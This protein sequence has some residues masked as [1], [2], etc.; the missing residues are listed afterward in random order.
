[1]LIRTGR[2]HLAFLTS[3]V[4]VVFTISATQGANAASAQVNVLTYHNNVRRNGLN[5]KEAILTPSKV[6]AGIFGKL[7]SLPVDGYIYAQPLYV[8]G[9]NIPGK[10]IHN[11][12]FVATEYDS[13]YAFAAGNPNGGNPL[14]RKTLIDP[15]NITSVSSS[16]LGCTD[17]VP[18]VGITGTPVINLTTKTLYVVSAAFNSNTSEYFQQL[19]ALD[20]RTGAE[21]FNGPV[22]ISASVPAPGRRRRRYGWQGQ[23]DFRSEDGESA[24]RAPA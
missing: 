17:L 1:M 13:V 15:A 12:G 23:C 2:L 21:K 19:H 6:K 16:A 9:L 3:I 10:G 18:E 8:L 4:A 24:R 11:V 22:T 20:L 14:W 7:F 5:W